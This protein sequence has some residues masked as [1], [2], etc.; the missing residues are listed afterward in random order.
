MNG[1]TTLAVGE[2]YYE[3]DRALM[4]SCRRSTRSPTANRLERKRVKLEQLIY[5]KDQIVK[6]TVA[7]PDDFCPDPTPT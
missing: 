4:R 5:L 7:E 3:V 1:S 2:N 6:S